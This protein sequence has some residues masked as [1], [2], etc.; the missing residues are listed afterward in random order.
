MRFPRLVCFGLGLLLLLAAGW[1]LGREEDD[2]AVLPTGRESSV[3]DVGAALDGARDADVH[4]PRL[5]GS[6]SP[7]GA[8]TA[9]EVPEQARRYRA[10][11][12]VRDERGEGI[13][14][15]EV[16]WQ[17]DA[18]EA[19]VTTART[20]AAGRAAA[21]L[22]P[23]R[24]RV[25]LGHGAQ[26]LPGAEA[27]PVIDLGG[28]GNRSAPSRS[29]WSVAWLDV[30]DRAP[31]PLVFQLASRSIRSITVVA[32]NATTGRPVA[33]VPVRLHRTGQRTSDGSLLQG[34]EGRTDGRGRAVF[35]MLPPGVYDI[36][37]RS[38]WHQVVARRVDVNA[39]DEEVEFELRPVGRVELELVDADGQAVAVPLAC[40]P[41][42]ISEE[43]AGVLQ[44][45]YKQ[46]GGDVTLTRVPPGRYQLQLDEWKS[47]AERVPAEA[48]ARGSAP[49][50]TVRFQPVEL[51][52]PVHVVVEAGERT[53]LRVQVVRRPRLRVTAL[54][55]E[56]QKKRVTLRLFAAGPEG[57]VIHTS[58]RPALGASSMLFSGPIPFGAYQ[59]HVSGDGIQTRVVEI[60]VDDD[61]EAFVI[62]LP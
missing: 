14:D 9:A 46:A 53:R 58:P 56:A 38:H 22:A 31:A 33:D 18:P 43:G 54:G 7:E 11:V 12:V 62:E 44:V 52:R 36:E 3:A 40:P 6:P 57:H 20:D 59:G 50:A 45:T 35:R 37:V 48:D 2:E 41:S 1:W 28:M 16:H 25:E 13:A 24:Y 27:Q 23:S 55:T 15:V 30:V 42:L 49:P 51:A 32:V 61:E 26:P 34:L 47:G 8:A 4:G 19:A 17:E 21:V 60:I 29:L 5:Q 39:G 10:E